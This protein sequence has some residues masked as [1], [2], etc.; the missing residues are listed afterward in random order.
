MEG[1]LFAYVGE[2]DVYLCCRMT[3]GSIR[4]VGGVYGS[5]QDG[6]YTFDFAPNP[7]PT[8][9]TSPE[10][11]NFSF[12]DGGPDAPYPILN[13]T[14]QVRDFAIIEGDATYYVDIYVDGVRVSGENVL[15]SGDPSP[16]IIPGAT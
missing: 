11:I 2:S 4:S 14:P 12:L 3:D 7:L 5:T 16:F 13:Y 15:V 8:D 6:V 1:S 9:V 10:Q